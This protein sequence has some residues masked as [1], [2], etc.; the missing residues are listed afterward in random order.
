MPAGL[1]GLV[2]AGVFAAAMSSLDSSMHSICTAVSNDFI[3]RFRESWSD[4]DQLNFARK[5]VGFL[6]ILGTVFALVLSSMDTGHILD[7]L[8]S[9]LGLI[10]SPLAGLFLLGLFVKRAKA[11][12]AWMGVSCSLLA[13]LY[14]KYFTDLNGLLYGLVGI[15]ICVGVGFLTSLIIPQ[16]QNA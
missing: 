3:K 14:S 1:A 8:V 13:I 4:S 7:L 12:H 5:L 10:G 9:I 15:G 16:K 2:I 11:I 6:G